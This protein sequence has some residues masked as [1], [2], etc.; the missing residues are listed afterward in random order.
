MS[1][2]EKRKEFTLAFKNRLVEQDI[3]EIANIEGVHQYI[4]EQEELIEAYKRKKRP[5]PDVLGILRSA[6]KLCPKNC[7]CYEPFEVFLLELN[8]LSYS[9]TFVPTLCRNCKCPAYFHPPLKNNLKFPTELKKGLRNTVLKE[10]NLNF[11]GILAIFD[12]DYKV[13]D[14]D[15]ITLKEQEDKLFL[16]LQHG[17]FSVVCRSIR[18]ISNEEKFVIEKNHSKFKETGAI[19]MNLLSKTVTFPETAKKTFPVLKEKLDEPLL[20]LCLTGMY[21]N[22]QSQ[23]GKFLTAA[24]TF[25][26]KGLKLLYTSKN[27]TQGFTD[28]TIFFPEIFTVKRTCVLIPIQTHSNDTLELD[29]LMSFFRNQSMRLK[30]KALDMNKDPNKL[31]IGKVIDLLNY[32]GFSITK[33]VEKKITDYKELQ[34]VLSNMME[35]TRAEFLSKF[36]LFN[37]LDSKIHAVG[38]SKI[39]IPLM[40]S[41]AAQSMDSFT[42]TGEKDTF[43]LFSYFLPNLVTSSRTLVVFRPITVRSG[44]NKL[45]LSLFKKNFFIVIFEEFKK[46]TANEVKVLASDS[47][48]VEESEFNEFMLDG[49][50]HIVVLSKLGC[51]EDAKV[52]ASGSINGRRKTEKRRLQTKN[53]NIQHEPEK[54][55]YKVK[56]NEDIGLEESQTKFITERVQVSSTLEENSIFALSPFSSISECLDLDAIIEN[57]IGNTQ[58]NLDLLNFEKQQREINRLRLFSRYFNIAVHVS[59]NALS[60]EAEILQ[61]CPQL[62]QY[63]DVILSLKPENLSLEKDALSLLK[64][65][66]VKFIN[67]TTINGENLYHVVKIAGR[68]EFQSVFEYKTAIQEILKPQHLSSIFSLKQFPNEFEDSLFAMSANVKNLSLIDISGLSSEKLEEVVGY[69][70]YLTS[71]ESLQPSSIEFVLNSLD[72]LH[73]SIKVSTVE[74]S[75]KEIRIRKLKEHPDQSPRVQILELF[76]E[77]SVISWYYKE[78]SKVHPKIVPN[79]F[80]FKID[81]MDESLNITRVYTCSEFKGYIFLKTVAE[82]MKENRHREQNKKERGSMVSFL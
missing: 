59:D 73:Y 27:S 55:P 21:T 52:L 13:I 7:D 80:D 41:L 43:F 9:N 19:F 65:M 69:C 71:N 45:F 81:P 62:C 53:F 68:V 6:C 1:I 16:L 17:G 23:F 2:E 50:C 66:N 3:K 39:G 5:L 61:F 30:G 40:L 74:N 8:E 10:D 37:S 63:S 28:C 75:V 32:N 26:P 18:I 60:A 72:F 44:L 33:D 11:S 58:D 24:M 4:V 64:N 57:Q 77:Y 51:I 76:D 78:T 70:L 36:M 15:L 14:Q 34:S 54:N 29:P 48:F 42:F 46:L 35:T 12:I 31:K 47:K 79:Y 49:E 22:A 20:I 82:M 56:L 38:A 67:S 25:L